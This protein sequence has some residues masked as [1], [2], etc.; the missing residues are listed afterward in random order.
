MVF[1]KAD[2]ETIWEGQRSNRRL[3]KG[4]SFANRREEEK[5]NREDYDARLAAWMEDARQPAPN[6][7][8]LSLQIVN[9]IIDPH[10]EMK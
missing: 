4:D 8:G 9:F 7:Q 10:E 5:S 3:R 2:L 6:L 1:H